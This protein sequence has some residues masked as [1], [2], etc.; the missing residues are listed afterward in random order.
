[1]QLTQLHREQW[2]WREGEET[3]KETQTQLT[4]NII[5]PPKGTL[6][7]TCCWVD[8]KDSLGASA[9]MTAFSSATWESST[10]RL[11]HWG[12][13]LAAPPPFKQ[14][15]KKHK[16]TNNC[17]I[18]AKFAIPPK[19]KKGCN[20]EKKI[21]ATKGL[22]D[23]KFL[24]WKIHCWS[25]NLTLT[26]HT[27]H[28]HGWKSLVFTTIYF[29]FPFISGTYRRVSR[30]LIRQKMKGGG[31]FF[32]HVYC[33][34]ETLRL[35]PCPPVPHCPEFLDGRRQ[36]QIGGEISPYQ[37]RSL[38]ADIYLENKHKDN[39]VS[40]PAWSHFLFS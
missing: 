8:G 6:S 12:R 26:S 3:E 24:P 38:F 14:K 18:C 30:P 10:E 36:K 29:H 33:C 23:T 19:K 22:R 17:K 32:H 16:T 34:G 20:R 40:D 25:P 21:N 11:E 2:G 7:D 5:T 4:H 13:D 1:M 9:G 31:F 15:Q 35:S 27:Q 37:L 28:C 39:S